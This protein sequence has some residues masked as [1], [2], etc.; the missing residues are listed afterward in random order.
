MRRSDL[1]RQIERVPP[2]EHPRADREQVVAP[3]EAA[4][5]LLF[6]ALAAGELEDRSVL[7]LGT[8][9]GRLAIGAALL[10]ARS[11][12][13]VDLDP[14]LLEV[15][16]RAATSA[17]ASVEFVASDVE[18]WHRRAELVVMNPPFGAQRA[19]ADRPFWDAAFRLAERSVYAFALADSRTFIAGRAVAAGVHV[20]ETRPVAWELPRTFP[21][22]TRR[23]VA[24][25]VDL[26]ALRTER[27]P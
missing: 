12:V 13:G 6:A 20:L 21:H 22:H 10:G 11:V 27:T 14:A 25:P 1:V 26:W 24:L 9:T 3:A 2:P 5:D 8:G 18:P 16:R 19:H 4:A 17:G 7:D 15:A 23:R